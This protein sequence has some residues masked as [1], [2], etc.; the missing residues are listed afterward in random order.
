MCFII[1]IALAT[2]GYDRSMLN[3]LRILDT[4]TKSFHDCQGSQLGLLTALYG[5]GSIASLPFVYV[6]PHVTYKELLFNNQQSIYCRLLGPEDCHRRWLRDHDC[7]CSGIGCS[8]KFVHVHGWA[9]FYGLW[10]LS[11]LNCLL[12]SCF[13]NCATLSIEVV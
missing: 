7:R 9:V 10:E 2:T 3:N 5:I 13:R 4:W 11:H 1:R 8:Q 12:H 6:L